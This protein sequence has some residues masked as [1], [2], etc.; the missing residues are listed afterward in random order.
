VRRGAAVG[1]AVNTYCRP[2]VGGEKLEK[3]GSA[4]GERGGSNGAERGIGRG[5]SRGR[6]GGRVQGGWAVVK[7]GEAA[8]E[9]N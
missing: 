8:V 6:G 2:G 9:A 5:G 3:A 7:R 1:A 4:G